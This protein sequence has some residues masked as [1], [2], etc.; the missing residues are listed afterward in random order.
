MSSIFIN[1]VRLVHNIETHKSFYILKTDALPKG[2]KEGKYN[3]NY[4][5]IFI[6]FRNKTLSIREWA[7]ET[8]IAERKIFKRYKS[9]WP[10]EKIFMRSFAFKS[11]S[12]TK[13]KHQKINYWITNGI[14][15]LQIEKGLPIPDIFLK[16]GYHLGRLSKKSTSHSGQMMISN[17]TTLEVKYVDKDSE[18]PNGWKKGKLR[19]PNCKKLRAYHK[20]KTDIY[21]SKAKEYCQFFVAND[22][23]F[24]KLVTQFPEL[25]SYRKSNYIL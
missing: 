17:S 18:I 6:T 25:K 22:L 16:S 9:N 1:S 21:I 3:K 14:K 24:T 5:G 2:C 13:R 20:K 10:V 12:K 7:K 19:K 11:P 15:E 4:D 23:S 8:N